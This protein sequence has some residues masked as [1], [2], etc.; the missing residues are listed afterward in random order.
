MIRPIVEFNPVHDLANF[1]DLME[2][3]FGPNAGNEQRHALAIDVFEKDNALVVSAAVPGVRPEEL[4]VAVENNI[5][6]ISG[7]S[8]AAIDT[9]DAKV[10]RIENR[11]G[12]FT[13]SLKLPNGLDLD[14][15]DAEFNHGMVTVKIPKV[16][17]KKPV[18]VRVPIRTTPTES[19]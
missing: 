10:Y 2:R 12:A 13:R 19:E 1:G 14:N 15:I 5:L 4:E 6:T 16:E 7:E 11:Y 3:M 17:I 18:P 8:K 9:N